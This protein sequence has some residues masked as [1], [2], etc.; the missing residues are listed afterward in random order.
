MIERTSLGAYLT[1]RKLL[2]VT[3]APCRL[4]WRAVNSG[5]ALS[6]ILLVIL[7][8]ALIGR[9]ASDVLYSRT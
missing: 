9:A 2:M 6:G 1:V 3:R 8:R 5:S 4:T 7:I